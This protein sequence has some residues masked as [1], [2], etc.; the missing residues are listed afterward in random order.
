[1]EN[2]NIFE[3]IEGEDGNFLIGFDKKFRNIVIPDGITVIE[4]MSFSNYVFIESVTIPNT[5][6]TIGCEAFSGCTNLESIT[7]P[8]S[9]T[10]IRD[11]AFEGCVNLKSIIIPDSVTSMGRGVFSGC[12]NLENIHLPHDIEDKLGEKYFVKF[13]QVVDHT[14][15]KLANSDGFIIINDILYGYVGDDDIIKIPRGVKIISQDAFSCTG[16]R[17]V[18]IPDSVTSIGHYAFY[19]CENLESVIIEQNTDTHIEYEAFPSECS[20]ELIST[21][22]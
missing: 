20:I 22:N 19:D 15:K 21:N 11:Y 10:S 6:T 7:I 17:H 2:N 8:D 4:D 1:M 14:C 12:T 5:V 9:V 13:P 3:I 16:I 18:I